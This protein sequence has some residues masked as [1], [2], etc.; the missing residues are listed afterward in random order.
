MAEQRALEANRAK[1]E[2]LAAMSHELRTPLNA[3][4]GFSEMLMLESWGPLGDQRYSGYAEDIHSAGAHLL[5]LINEVLDLAKV[6]AGHYELHDER[7]PVAELVNSC[8]N[9]VN[10][11]AARKGLTLAGRA[12]DG[13][14]SIT[15]DPRLLRQILLN[16]LSNAV[17]FTPEGGTVSATAAHTEDG[18]LRLTVTDSG[19]GIAVG[20]LERVMQPFGQVDSELARK[21][22]G[23]STGLGLPLVK[24][25]VELHG[26]RLELVSTPDSGTSVSA[27]FPAWRCH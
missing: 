10:E 1:T 23:E 7:V 14:D 27:V 13:V 19:I 6:E 25:F 3:I 21:H 17:K 22:S 16:L 5:S 26:G 24:R 11:R 18:G 15:A 12:L 8:L 4:I 9:L 20:D 2:F